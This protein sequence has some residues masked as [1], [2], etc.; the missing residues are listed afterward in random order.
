MKKAP[1]SWSSSNRDSRQKEVSLTRLKIGHTRITHSYFISPNLLSPPSCP[2]C[3]Q[4]NLS[5]IHFFTCQQLQHLRSFLNI[6]SPISQAL[7][8]YSESIFLSSKYQRQTKFLLLIILKFPSSNSLLIDLIK[9]RLVL[10]HS[11]IVNNKSLVLSPY[12]LL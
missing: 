4:K 1:R 10:K 5:V 9:K 11:F 8:N 6:P 12:Q 7:K 3:F 2:H